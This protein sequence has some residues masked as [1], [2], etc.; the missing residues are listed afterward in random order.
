M[1]QE[2]DLQRAERHVRDGEKLVAEQKERIEVLRRDGHP[3]LTAEI[4][5][6]TFEDSLRIYRDGLATLH[7]ASRSTQ[8]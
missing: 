5:L 1:E 8:S 2:T 6:V 3:T 4:L 7:A